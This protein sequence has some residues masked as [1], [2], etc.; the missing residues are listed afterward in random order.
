MQ[1]RILSLDAFRLILALCVLIGHT[2][3]VLYRIGPS[4]CG[5]Q[6][7]AVDGFFILS[8]FFMGLGIAKT[9]FSFHED[10]N[11]VFLKGAVKRF[12]RL[13]PEYFFALLFVFIMK[14]IFFHSYEWYALPFNLILI[15][16]VDKVPGIVNGS[17]YVSVLF[18]GGSFISYLLL[19]K[20][21][22]A[23]CF[24]LPMV[25]FLSFMY[26]YPVYNHL[27]LHGTNHFL[28]GAYSMGFIK[29]I[30]DMAIGVE[31]FFVSHYLKSHRINIKKIY[32]KSIVLLFEG[33]GLF[34]MLYAWTFKGVNYT[35]FLVL[36]GYVILLII[37]SLHREIF[38]SFLSWKKWQYISPVA[39]MLFLT[40]V[41]WL[42]IIKKYIPYQNYPEWVV[43]ASIVIFCTSFAFV[44]YYAQK[45]IFA[46]LK[47]MIMIP[48][49]ETGAKNVG[50]L[51][52]ER[53]RDSF[54][55]AS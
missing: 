25:I 20:Q 14:G 51:E 24:Y 10:I 34:L 31:C 49:P 11:Y 45:K 22:A 12:C 15:S 38:L 6:N 47:E 3:V 4:K 5:V 8:G 17:W 19:T 26:I 1:N 44:C 29:G 48:Q 37:L 21:K 32:K 42:T 23:F 2:Y 13:W 43:Y 40:H 36:F 55:Q 50:N 27:S 30:M 28:F 7:I 33:L 54:C 16:Q 39:Y 52:R 18:W 41:L 35:N 53:E 46:K 9:A